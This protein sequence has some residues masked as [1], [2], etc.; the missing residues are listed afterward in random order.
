MPT[1]SSFSDRGNC[2]EVEKSEDLIYI[3]DPDESDTD[4]VHVENKMQTTP[5]NFDIWI[6]GV[7]EGEFD[8]FGTSYLKSSI[9]KEEWDILYQVNGG[10]WD[11]FSGSIEVGDNFFLT[12]N[13]ILEMMLCGRIGFMAMDAED[14]LGNFMNIKFRIISF[15]Y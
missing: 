4:N 10:D 13:R 9:D 2:I 6:K 14:P 5:E 11:Q 1:K 8:K 3:S 7:K 15:D 12:Y